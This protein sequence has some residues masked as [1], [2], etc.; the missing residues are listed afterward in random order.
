MHEF[1][2]TLGL[3]QKPVLTFDEKNMVI[4]EEGIST[5]INYYFSDYISISFINEGY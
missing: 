1:L 5:S 2:G 4:N 3:F